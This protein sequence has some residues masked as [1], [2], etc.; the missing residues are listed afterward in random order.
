MH[1]SAD[2]GECALHETEAA[3]CRRRC[4]SLVRSPGLSLHSMCRVLRCRTCAR[5]L[6]CAHAPVLTWDTLTPLL[7][8][9]DA[10]LPAE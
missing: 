7:R 9:L 5:C 4:A 2:A 8:V 6:C 3:L 10:Q 1:G